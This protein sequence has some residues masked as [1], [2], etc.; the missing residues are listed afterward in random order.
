MRKIII[1]LALGSVISC[2]GSGWSSAQKEYY[3]DI[4]SSGGYVSEAYCKC[5]LKKIISDGYTP[6]DNVPYSAMERYAQQCL[7]LL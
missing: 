6:E 2:S 7:Y 1:T 5:T 3:V 4:C